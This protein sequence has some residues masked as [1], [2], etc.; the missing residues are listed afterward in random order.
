[1]KVLPKMRV[2]YTP[3]ESDDELLHKRKFPTLKFSERGE[4]MRFELGMQFASKELAKEAVK[5]HAME[6]RTNLKFKK[7]DLTRLVVKCLPTF[8]YNMLIAKRDGS[9]YWQVTSL[10]PDHECVLTAGN[11]QAKTEWLAKKFIPLIRHTPNI[12]PSGLADEAFTRWN[13]SLN[14]FQ[15]YRAKRRALELL[16]GAGSEQ[17]AHLRN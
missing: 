15:A 12:K 1:M 14:H 6:T 11:T 7:N 8:S 2:I 10:K 16:D 13:V 4:P 9:Q 5:D 3:I 17:Y